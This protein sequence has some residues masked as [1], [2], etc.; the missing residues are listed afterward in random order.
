MYIESGSTLLNT[1]L[2]R[3][4]ENKMIEELRNLD[5]TSQSSQSYSH[6]RVSVAS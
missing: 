5:N 4:I 2:Q 1:D 6:C 3:E